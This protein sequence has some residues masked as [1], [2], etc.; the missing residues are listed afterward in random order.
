M[1]EIII[2]RCDGLKYKIKGFIETMGISEGRFRVF[3]G[4]SYSKMTIN[5]APL[6]EYDVEK[7]MEDEHD[8]QKN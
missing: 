6:V 7:V 4:K 3:G 2:K 5:I 1:D 8:E